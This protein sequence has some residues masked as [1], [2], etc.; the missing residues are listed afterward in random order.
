[1]RTERLR[2][3]RLILVPNVINR[4]KNTPN[5]K[6]HTK[7]SKLYSE[8]SRTESCKHKNQNH[9]IHKLAGSKYIHVKTTKLVEDTSQS[10]VTLKGIL[11]NF[12]EPCRQLYIIHIRNLWFSHTGS[13][14]V[15]LTFMVLVLK[16]VQLDMSVQW[17][18]SYS[19]RRSFAILPVPHLHLAW[20]SPHWP[21][22]IP[23]W[24]TTAVT[25]WSE[26]LPIQ[27]RPLIVADHASGKHKTAYMRSLM[28]DII[29]E[30][31]N[32][33]HWSLLTVKD[34]PVMKLQGSW[35]LSHFAQ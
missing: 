4:S 8:C 21:W 16:V 14:T 27:S 35:I 12:N 25:A 1:M 24:E 3:L 20:Y 28:S 23:H 34:L 31:E 6:H 11:I 29:N 30:A 15:G 19:R 17:Q 18:T 10:R 33:L 2:Y 32:R 22:G 13:G 26:R 7:A 5:T 9:N